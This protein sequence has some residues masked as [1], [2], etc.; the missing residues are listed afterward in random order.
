[1]AGPCLHAL[2]SVYVRSQVGY[3]PLTGDGL[4]WYIQ[5][6]ENKYDTQSLVK[7]NRFE[8]KNK[9][10]NRDQSISKSIEMLTTDV[11]LVQIWKSWLQLGLTNSQAQNGV[12][13]YLE[14]KLDF[15]GQVQSSPETK[16]ILTKVFYSYGAKLV[17]QAW[18][19]DEL[20]CGRTWWRMDWRTDGQTQAMTIPGGQNLLW[21]FGWFFVCKIVSN[22]TRWGIVEILI[23]SITGHV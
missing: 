10:K 18:T 9:T 12:N 6:D 15:E 2:E 17:I 20:S 4:T 16:G 11:F 1:M 3:G 23:S 14:V 21:D 19:D 13:V 8:I 22:L 7:N 5:N